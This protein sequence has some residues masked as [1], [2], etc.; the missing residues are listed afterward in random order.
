MINWTIIENL[1]LF[2]QA[3]TGSIFGTWTGR[4]TA[5]EQRELFGRYIGKGKIIINGDDTTICNRVRV[6]FG[7]DYDDRN[8][9]SWSQL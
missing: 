3:Q 2:V 9:T 5:A 8:M 4:L 7:L 6:C 1:T